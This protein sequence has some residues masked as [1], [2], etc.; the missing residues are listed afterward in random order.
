ME[1]EDNRKKE[2]DRQRLY[3]DVLFSGY[4]DRDPADDLRYIHEYFDYLAQ[5][6]E[7]RRLLIEAPRELLTRFES[8]C[9]LLQDRL[10]MYPETIQHQVHQI[11]KESK[12]ESVLAMMGSLSDEDR[13]RLLQERGLLS[14]IVA[15]VSVLLGGAQSGS[16]ADL[17]TSRSLFGAKTSLSRLAGIVRYAS[18]IGLSDFDSG[19]EELKDH[20]DPA[21]VDKD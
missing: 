8:V 2:E 13:R 10:R 1:R 19:A 20:Y 7:Y 16:I 21:L 15:A 5:R 17:P 14:R 6:I 4:G 18:S 3:I 12:L 9:L 11:L